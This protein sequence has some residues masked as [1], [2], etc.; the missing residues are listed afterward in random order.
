MSMSQ[1]KTI[2]DFQK[3]GDNSHWLVINDGVMG[4]LSQGHLEI[5]ELGYGVFYGQVSL[6]NN[7][8]FSSVRHQFDPIDVSVF[9]SVKLRVKGDGK[10]Y[11]LRVKTSTEDRHAYI[12]YFT[13]SGRWQNIEIQ[14]S[15]LYPTFRGRRLDQANYPKERMA[16]IAFLIAN[17]QAESFQLE[18]DSITLE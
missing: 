9:S 2:F 3:A 17:K 4:G 12:S 15:D 13:T 11:Q 10:R 1:E 5:N 14:L 18:I 6:E 7:G 8:G 16:E